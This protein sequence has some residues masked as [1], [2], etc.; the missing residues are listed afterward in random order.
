MDA[1]LGHPCVSDRRL[2]QREE[3]D[4]EPAMSSAPSLIE[5]EPALLEQDPAAL[6][7]RLLSGIPQNGPMSLDEHLSIHGLAP[8][9]RPRRR[10]EESPLIARIERAGLC[11]RGGARFPTARKLR[12]VASSRG[13]P[14]VVVNAAEGEPASLKDRTLT[15]SLP[16]LVLDGG[17]LAAQAVGAEELIVCVCESAVASAESIAAAIAERP[18]GAAQVRLAVVPDHYVAGQE[19]ALVNCH[20]GGPATPTFTPPMP[21][22]QGVRRRPTLINN[23]ETLAHVALIARHGSQW[24]RRLGGTTQPGSTLVT[25]S[26]PVAHPGVYEIELGCSLS[27]LLAAAG[28][29]TAGV[30]AALLG[31]YAGTWIDGT[32]L[33]G[34]TL[35]DE[36]LAPHGASVG[37]GVV[38]LLSDEACPVAETARVARWLAGQS[39]GQCGPCVNGLAALSATVSDIAGG[40]AEASATQRIER[41]AAL[42]RRRGACGHPDGTVNF[43]LS[44]LETFA[45][46][47]ADHARHGPCEACKH[48]AE[49][50]LG[51]SASPAS[52][53]R[54]RGR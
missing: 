30:G 47:F 51:A 29:M 16:H 6:L 3:V 35:S 12:A 32:L 23:A 9:A 13:R 22:E 10:R 33:R 34:L 20:N 4:R 19:S 44:A 21:F 38:L 42:V 54:A 27:S 49:L 36:H 24:F 50:P 7:P 1:T 41:L 8:S 53:E 25:L 15:Y 40:V 52:Q 48:P 37:A 31:G 5:V 43:V 2:A 45:P 46:A 18:R 39:T 26:G 14:V 17:E 28:G 11:G